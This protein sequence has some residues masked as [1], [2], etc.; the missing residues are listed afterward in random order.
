MKVMGKIYNGVT[1]A[2]VL[3]MSS[4]CIGHAQ[5][6]SVLPGGVVHSDFPV[7]APRI[8]DFDPSVFFARE[9]ALR[10]VVMLLASDQMEGRLTGSVQD[11]LSALYIGGAFLHEKLFPLGMDSVGSSQTD[12]WQTYEFDARWGEHVKSRNVVGVVR[13]T[14]PE[15]SRRYVVVGAHFDHLGWGDKA[16]NSMRKGVRAIH[17]GAD[18][19]ASGVAM[20]IELM[21][22]YSLYPT[23]KSIVFVAFSGEE[24]GLCGSKAFI[25]KFPYGK[26]SI[27]AMFNLD[28]LGGLNGDEFRVSGVG[29]S[30]EA[31]AMVDRAAERTDLKLTTSKDGHG[32]SD[33]AVFYAEQIP[34]FFFCTPP[35]STYHTPDDDAGRLNYQGMVRISGVIGD[36]LKQVGNS[37]PLVFRSTGKPEGPTMGMGKFKVTLGLMPD[38]NSDGDAGLPVM[39]VV[40]GKPAYKAGIRTGDV[41]LSMEGTPISN[42][43][44][45]MKK[46]STFNK[47]QK[48]KVRVR[49]KD[50]GKEKTFKVKL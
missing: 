41:I 7:M 23:K 27:D 22:Y 44:E 12:Y 20:M 15:L 30:V 28:M 49:V 16:E 37:Q 14:D 18:D 34:V 10:Q 6:P 50:T 4:V 32:P 36:L 21:R 2:A 47:G 8:E 17:N 46:L 24:V 11:S 39:I 40:E 35:T 33:H 45:Y 13:G 43:D 19:N 1:L 29:T 25:E 48:I 9:H 42:I 38:I 5:E 3:A 31:A 26:E